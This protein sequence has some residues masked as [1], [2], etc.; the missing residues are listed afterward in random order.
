[1]DGDNGDYKFENVL[2]VRMSKEL[3]HAVF[4]AAHD[5]RTSMNTF[6]IGALEKAVAQEANGDVRIT[7]PACDHVSSANKSELQTQCWECPS[8]L[9]FYDFD[10]R[11]LYDAYVE[12]CG[13]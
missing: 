13:A 2:T 1:M 7:C 9:D 12:E 8:C 4:V 10:D 5:A 6:A 3:H 11:D